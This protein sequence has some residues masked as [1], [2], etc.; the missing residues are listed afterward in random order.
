MA[1]PDQLWPWKAIQ[2][3]CKPQL[4]N[5]REKTESKE[6]RQRD[7][8]WR[9]SDRPQN[10]KCLV[11]P[12]SFQRHSKFRWASPPPQKELL[13]LTLPVSSQ[14]SLPN[15]QMSPGMF[16][17]F[18][19]HLLV[20][21]WERVNVARPSLHRLACHLGLISPRHPTPSQLFMNFLLHRKWNFSRAQELVS[22]QK[23]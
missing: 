1:S 9:F 20:E 12:D 5:R 2:L 19:Y 21:E 7:R 23:F 15:T 17:S 14:H 13:T 22:L 10:S 4:S 8:I 11:G 18:V 3:L 6:Q 16:S